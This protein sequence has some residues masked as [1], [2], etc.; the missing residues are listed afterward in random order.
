MTRRC[1]V[2]IVIWNIDIPKSFKMQLSFKLAPTNDSSWF[3]MFT[4]AT[5]LSSSHCYVR[6]TYYCE[7]KSA[8]TWIK[9]RNGVGATRALVLEG[10]WMLR[11]QAL[12]CGCYPV[13]VMVFSSPRNRSGCFLMVLSLYGQ[14]AEKRNAAGTICGMMRKWKGGIGQPFSDYGKHLAQGDD[15]FPWMAHTSINISEYVREGQEEVMVEK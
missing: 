7:K 1:E 11:T 9:D 13:I 5:R 3:M 4:S 15:F 2:T 14:L 6:Y 8:W 10:K 12:N